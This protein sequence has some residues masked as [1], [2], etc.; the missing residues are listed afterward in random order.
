MDLSAPRCD[1]GHMDFRDILLVLI[2]V[3]IVV[4]LVLAATA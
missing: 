4:L 3:G 2:L 1:D